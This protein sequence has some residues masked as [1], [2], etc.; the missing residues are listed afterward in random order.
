MDES[1]KVIKEYIESLEKNYFPQDPSQEMIKLLDKV[2]SGLNATYQAGLVDGS[3][4][5]RWN[6][7]SCL[8]FAVMAAVRVGMDEEAIK[9]LI[10]DILHSFNF[11][12]PELA[13]A[14]YSNS[15]YKL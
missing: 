8:G 9:K 1:Q 14:V 10:G 2:E 11:V 4:H 5:L 13:A 6:N 12:G 3:D 15:K 7:N